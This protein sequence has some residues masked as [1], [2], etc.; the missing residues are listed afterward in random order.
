MARV[1]LFSTQTPNV[2]AATSEGPTHQ[3][4]NFKDNF[5]LHLALLFLGVAILH[6]WPVPGGNEHPYLLLP[7]KQWN[8]NYLLNDWTLSEPWHTHLVF[9]I[10]LAPLTPLLPIEILGWLGRIASWSLIIIA[11]LRLGRHFRVPLSMITL[12]LFLWLLFGQSI[13][14]GE[15]IVGGFEAKTVSYA[16]LLFSLEGLLRKRDIYASILLGI[17]FS[18]HPTVVFLCGLAIGLS[19]IV[20]QYPLRRLLTMALSATLF[21]LPGVISLLPIVFGNGGGS[22]EDWKFFVLIRSPHHLDPFSWPKRDIA[23]LYV[24]MLFNVLHSLHNKHDKKIAFFISFQIFL[25]IFFSLGLLASLTENYGFLK[26]TPFRLFP[27]FTLLFFF[28]H[29][30]NAYHY[31]PSINLRPA[32]VLVGFLALLCFSNPIG[33]FMDRVS[34]TYTIWNDQNDDIQQAFKWLSRNTPNGSIAI[35]PPWRRDSFY[36]A[37]RAHIAQWYAVPVDRLSEWRTRIAA[38]VGHNW[39]HLPGKLWSE[40]MELAYNKMNG[41]DIEAL[42]DKYGG[43]YLVSKSNY[44]YPV[45]FDSG[46]YRVYAL[47]GYHAR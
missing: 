39:P 25:C 2:I 16:C 13:V 11:L 31:S 27:L 37:Q 3:M 33:V 28:F 6:G 1:R 41:Q 10:V 32:L 14:G 43:E 46:T 20:L 44:M 42:V 22:A 7:I 35:L 38:M 12:S 15:W 4:P 9:N 45:L 17:A 8:P 36:V 34:E 21:A 26:L 19:L 23:F 30:M 29:L 18:F 40:K 47:K 5:L 24:L